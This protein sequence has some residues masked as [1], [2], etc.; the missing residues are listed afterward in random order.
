MSHLS[1]L[2][3]EQDI[4][5]ISRL[6]DLAEKSD[7]SFIEAEIGGLA[8]R[9][10]RSNAPA[11]AVARQ[12]VRAPAVGIYRADA[13]KPGAALAAGAVVG[14]IETL[15]QQTNVVTAKGGRFTEL[16]VQDGDFVEY[17]QPLLAVEPQAV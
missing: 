10:E 8:I 2:L 6:L 5:A 15:D 14:R 1:G 17:G 7:L 12:E 4:E 3:T 16:L 13:L 9:V 11:A